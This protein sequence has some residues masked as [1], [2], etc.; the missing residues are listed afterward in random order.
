LDEFEITGIV[1]DKDG[2]ISHCGVKG[3]GIQ[4]IE[5]MEKLIMEEVCSF[6]VYVGEEKKEMYARSSTDGVIFLTTDPNGYNKDTLNFLPLL[7][8]PLFKRLIEP[9]R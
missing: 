1:R 7:D 2:T 8:K 3:Y 4:T 9:V 6:F 5:L